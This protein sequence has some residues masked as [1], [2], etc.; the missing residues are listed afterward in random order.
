MAIMHFVRVE[1]DRTVHKEFNGA[2][3]Y[4]ILLFQVFAYFLK[5]KMT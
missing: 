4:I 1:L 5:R 2:Y 3:F